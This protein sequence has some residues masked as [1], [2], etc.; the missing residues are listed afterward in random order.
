M[1]SPGCWHHQGRVAV[2][3]ATTLGRCGR[4][5]LLVNI[6]HVVDSLGMRQYQGGGAVWLQKSVKYLILYFRITNLVLNKNFMLYSVIIHNIG[7]RN[8]LLIL[9]DRIRS[10]YWR[11]AGKCLL[12]CV[13]G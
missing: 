11:A 6:S 10:L 8:N 1:D 7:Y 3:L 4:V 2:W 12:G 13:S 5:E 9:L